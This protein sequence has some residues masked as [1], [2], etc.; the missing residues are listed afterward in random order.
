[1]S[2][3]LRLGDWRD[4][5]A[6]V[7]CDALIT[8]PPFSERTAA[9]FIGQNKV[10]R[11]IH[12]G[13]ITGADARDVAS[14]ARD[15]ARYWA[16]VFSDHT[17]LPAWE[18]AF[19]DVG[20]FVFAPLAWVKNDAPPRFMGD[21]PA[22]GLEWITVARPRVKLPKER[23]GSRPPWYKTNISKDFFA[24]SKPVGVMRAIVC[25]Y[26]LAGDTVCDMYSGTGTTAIAAEGLGRRF[27][28][29]EIDP[30]THAKAIK[31]IAGGVQKEM[32]A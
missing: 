32:F 4:V 1:M 26:T 21:G 27:I 6:D 31:R 30:D 5:L 13:S 23:I 7:E 19:R 8:D 2:I 10:K 28:G 18:S 9:G 24:G 25:D 22:S 17:L 20:W 15:H 12:Y 16:V 14:W 11:R 3:D 29:A